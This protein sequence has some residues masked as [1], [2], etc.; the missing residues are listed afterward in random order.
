MMKRALLTLLIVAASSTLWACNVPVFRYALERWKPDL[1]EVI[2]F[3]DADLSAEQE[4]VLANLQSANEGAQRAA[5]VQVVRSRVGHDN[6]RRNS[7]LWLTLKKLPEVTLPYVVVRTTVSEKQAVNG[8]HGPLA[9]FQS[10][11][12]LDSPARRE[13]S[14]RLLAGDSV[15]WLV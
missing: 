11:T 13:L 1:C 12:L 9:Q 7:E 6:D 5:N 3:S 14:K 2:V 10:A 15:V 8:W 4:K